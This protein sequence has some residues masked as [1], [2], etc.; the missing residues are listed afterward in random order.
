MH[1]QRLYSI[2]AD[3]ALT[4]HVG[5]VVFVVGGIFLIIWS[6]LRNG[7]IVRSV[8]FRTAH[9]VAI[10]IVAAQAWLGVVCP[11]TTLEN[12]LRSQA[13]ETTYSG[14]FI[15]HWLDQLLYYDAAPWIFTLSYTLFGLAVLATW[16]IFPPKQH[17]GMPVLNE[18]NS[19]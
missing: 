5:I 4:L 18:T 9:L 16:I 12:W 11:L 8:V 17:K 14:G 2:F 10:G 19:K 7:K 15:A 1:P 6:G 13:H 3:I